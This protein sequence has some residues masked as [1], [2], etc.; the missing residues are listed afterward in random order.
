MKKL[1]SVALVLVLALALGVSAFAATN[2]S[3]DQLTGMIKGNNI[4]TASQKALALQVV[5]EMTDAQIAAV[6]AD[7]IKAQ[8][9]GVQTKVN[10][11]TLSAADVD[12]AI[13][14]INAALG[15]DVKVA[16]SDL[17][18][19]TAKGTVTAK[20][21]ATVGGKAVVTNAS[22]AGDWKVNSGSTTTTPV[23][24]G[25]IKS[26]GSNL[27]TAATV[28]ALAVAGVLGVATVKA[29]KLEMGA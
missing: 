27:Q 9:E 23:T 17:A 11:G 6:D 22:V 10:A 20:A 1:I 8:A 21:T 12:A 26:T 19:D 2:Y 29:R 5:N 18:I 7:I 14:T 13:N 25:V 4:A 28:V 16:L 15:S 24:T 3:R